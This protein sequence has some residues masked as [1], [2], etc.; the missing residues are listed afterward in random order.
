VNILRYSKERKVKFIGYFVGFILSKSAVFIAPLLLSNYLNLT[1]YGNLEY[2]ISIGGILSM[3]LG[4]GTGASYSI[5]I[6]KER[7]TDYFAAFMLYILGILGCSILFIWASVLYPPLQS[8]IYCWA[9]LICFI[10]IAQTFFSAIYKT[11]AKQL[12]AVFLDSGMYIFF[13]TFLF[14]AHLFAFVTYRYLFYGLELY[15]LLI[16]VFMIIIFRHRIKFSTQDFRKLIKI[17][18]KGYPLVISSFLMMSMTNSGR[19]L[20]EKYCSTDD[21]AQYSFYFR[22]AAGIMLFHQFAGIMFYKKIFISSSVR[23]DKYF[24]AFFFA[25][26]SLNI[27]L[28]IAI[29]IAGKNYLKLLADFSRYKELYFLLSV[30]VAFWSMTALNEALIYRENLAGKMNICLVTILGLSYLI[31]ITIAH[32]NGLTALDIVKAHFG[33]L[34]L[35]LQAQ[36]YLL[37]K[38]NC[39]LNKLRVISVIVFIATFIIDNLLFSIK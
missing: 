10:L 4:L 27:A 30:L 18:Y 38:K 3:V 16:I 36:L 21:L 31:L 26:V 33:V 12:Q 28:Y 15:L 11:H 32:F 6:L 34:F 35:V 39:A 13:V 2:G 7:K 23:L 19:I 29:P 20:I 1:T 24:S 14:A 8:N 17:A 22:L 25:M 37:Q 5:L 9:V